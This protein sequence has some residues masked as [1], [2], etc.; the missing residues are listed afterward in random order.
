MRVSPPRVG[1]ESLQH[2]GADTVSHDINLPDEVVDAGCRFRAGV[3]SPKVINPFGILTDAVAL[4]EARRSASLTHNEVLGATGVD[5]VAEVRLQ[6]FRRPLVMPPGVDVGPSE[7]APELIEIGTSERTEDELHAGIVTRAWRAVKKARR[8]DHPA[9]RSRITAAHKD[10]PRGI[11]AW[12]MA[13]D[14]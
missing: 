7:P 5:P 3:G 2:S 10:F 1:D 11:K 6:R 13:V 14:A 12:R 9:R 8:S 4:Y